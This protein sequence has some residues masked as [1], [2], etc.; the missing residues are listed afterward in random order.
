MRLLIARCSV[1]YTG[2]LETRLAEA[3]RL[4]MVKADGSVLVHS[5]GGSYKPLNWMSP[6]CT[7]TTSRR[8]DAEDGHLGEVV[9][10]DKRVLDHRALG[11]ATDHATLATAFATGKG[12]KKTSILVTNSPSFVVNR[13]L[14]R[15]MGE[16]GRV[17]AI[18][19]F[20]AKTS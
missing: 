6:P 7:L 2:R 15:F 19:G 12:L 13:L 14:G 1:V 3:T 9:S 20:G 5:D 18:K 10:A 4:I 17:A 11:D 16:A 8:D